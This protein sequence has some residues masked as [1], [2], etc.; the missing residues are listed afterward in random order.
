MNTVQHRGAVQNCAIDNKVWKWTKPAFLIRYRIYP[1]SLFQVCL[2]LRDTLLHSDPPS[3]VLFGCMGLVLKVFFCKIL[4]SL[5][6][7]RYFHINICCKLEQ[8]VFDACPSFCYSSIVQTGPSLVLKFQKM[9]TQEQKVWGNLSWEI[10]QYPNISIDFHAVCIE[11]KSSGWA[12]I[13]AP[14]C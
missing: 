6:N 9:A 11:R 12:M 1:R 13:A 2:Y 10:L 5:W 8:F 4:N 14:Q 7:S 3:W